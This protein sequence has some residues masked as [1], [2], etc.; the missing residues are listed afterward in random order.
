MIKKTHF[1]DEKQ[2]NTKRVNVNIKKNNN[3]IL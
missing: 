2:K 3:K 1:F